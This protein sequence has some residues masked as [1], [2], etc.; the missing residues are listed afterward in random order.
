MYKYNKILVGLDNTDT[1]YDLIKAASDVSALSGSNLVYF[2][3]VIRDFNM[4]EELLREF[5]QLLDKAIEERKEELEKK[6]NAHFKYEDVKV[7]VKVIVKQGQVTKFLLKYASAEK[8]DL[9][10]LGRKNEKKNGGVLVNRVAR[11]A[12]CSLLIIPKGS[13]FKLNQILVPTDFSDY[14]KKAMEKAITLSKK[15]EGESKIIV[16]NV[17][18]VPVGYHYTG[19]SFKEFSDIMKAHAKNDY[20]KFMS[21]LRVKG[22]NIEQVYTLDK[23]EDITTDIY[24]TAKRIKA[25]LIVIGAKGRTATTA[26]FIGSKAEKLIQVDSDIPMLV[27]RPKG[28]NAGFL[29]YIREI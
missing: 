21:T 8:I 7:V 15:A 17:Y 28:K 2:I 29:E 10:V 24:K 23:D 25:S 13:V 18:T 26:I 11:R 4:P 14:A 19:K 5:P 12:G 22:V 27:V 6:V 9:V 20:Q 16:Q 1:D 3:N